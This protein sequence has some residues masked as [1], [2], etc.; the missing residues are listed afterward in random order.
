RFLRLRLRRAHG[1]LLRGRRV[2]PLGVGFDHEFVIIGSGFGGSVSAL[3]LAEKGYSV[4]VLE[5]GKRWKAEDFPKTNWNLRRFIWMPRLL[6]HGF[7]QITLLRDVLVFHGAGVGGGSL[8]YANTLLV[9]PDAFFQDP[10]W[11]DLADWKAVLAPHYATAK[12]MLGVTEAAFLAETDEHLREVARAMG[13][14]HTFHKAHV[15]VFFGEPGKTVP[16]PFFG[17]EGPER[18]GCTLCAGCM[19]GCRHGA[20][21]TLDRNYLYLAEKKGVKI[22]PETHVTDIRPLEGGGYELATER[23]TSLVFK[24]RRTLRAKNVVVSAGV[25]GTVKLLMACRDRGSL[26]AL[27]GALGGYVRTN[28]E[29]LIGIKSKDRKVDLSKGIAIS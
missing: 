4:L 13:R 20:K 9:P 22:I 18:T 7:Q 29:A 1:P 25:L 21:N 16:D 3:R 15:G 19:V 14:E 6:L 11:S 27:P 17:G 23:S 8:V 2:Y 12:R 28:S 26:P 5:Q 10:K 24:A